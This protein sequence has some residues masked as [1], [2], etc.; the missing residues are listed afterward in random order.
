M[1]IGSTQNDP[2]FPEHSGY[3]QNMQEM[4]QNMKPQLP[5]AED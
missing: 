2:I 5:Q 3:D 4:T 1:N